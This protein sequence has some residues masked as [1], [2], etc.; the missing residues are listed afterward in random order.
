MQKCKCEHWQVCPACAPGMFD[1]NGKRKPPEPTPLQACRAALDALSEA[2]REAAEHLRNEA[3]ELQMAHTVSGEWDGT[4]PEAMDECERLI[5]LADRLQANA[6][7]SADA[8]G[9]RLE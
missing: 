4:E 7:N 9:G 1:A 6:T 3:A 2:A 5:A 8:E